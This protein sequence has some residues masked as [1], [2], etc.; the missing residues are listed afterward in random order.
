MKEAFEK[1][2]IWLKENYEDGLKDLNP[3]ATE[4]EIRLLEQTL[5][6]SLPKDFIECLKIHNG[7]GNMAGG[8]FDGAEFLST[9]RIIEEWSVWKELLDSGDFDD[10][11]SEPD[12]GIKSDWWNPKWI[13]FTSNGAGDHFCIDVD[14][15]KQGSA[16]QIIT[17]WHDSAERE[18]LADSFSTWFSFYVSE[19]LKGKYAYSDDYGFIVPIED[20]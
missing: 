17:M 14:P 7:Q 10:Y 1:F 13:P 5:G 12:E 15:E 11:E 16:G 19:I 6:C 2:K 4:D 3:P 8:I 20:L 9:S 18:L